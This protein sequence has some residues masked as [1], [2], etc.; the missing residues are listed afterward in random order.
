VESAD[1]TYAARWRAPRALAAVAVA[2]AAWLLPA[3]DAFAVPEPV[4]GGSTTLTLELPKKVKATPLS[5][6]TASGDTFTLTNTGGTTDISK[7]TAAV[8]VSGGIRLKGKRGKVALTEIQVAFGP[9]GQIKARIKN[10]TV[11]LALVGGTIQATSSGASAPQTAATLTDDGAKALNKAFAKKK[12][13]K[14][15]GKAA[16]SGSRAKPFHEGNPLGTASTTLSLNTV[17]VRAEGQVALEPDPGA[18]LTF[19]GK[20]VNFLTGGI[21]AVAPA[22]APSIAEFDF[23]VTGGRV[24]PDLS[25]GQIRSAGGLLITK[26]QNT[27]NAGCD[28][29]HPIGI[30]IKQTDLI[31]D[32][33]R[34][35]LLA[36][37]DSSGGFIGMGAVTADLDMSNATKSVNPNGS[38]TIEGMQVKITAI[39]ASTLNSIFGSASQGCGSDFAEGDSLGQ[40]SVSTTVG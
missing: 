20:G 23:P 21:S 3:G 28:G 9:S 14:K 1:R 15:K 27:L 12:K 25:G 39:S 35:A 13:G 2:A 18:G 7:G 24:I 26:N 29:T 32:L 40:L 37:L 30:F 5:P 17:E 4:A 11:G 31:V 33:D 16:A 38:A 34:K 10:K 22:T 6:A 19:L 36:T 8:D